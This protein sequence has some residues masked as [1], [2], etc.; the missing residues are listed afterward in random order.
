MLSLYQVIRLGLDINMIQGQYSCVSINKAK[1]CWAKQPHLNISA[2]QP[3]LIIRV[4]Q[5]HDNRV[6]GKLG[7]PVFQEKYRVFIE[8]AILRSCIL[9]TTENESKESID[10]CLS[11]LGV[12]LR[13]LVEVNPVIVSLVAIERIA[14]LGAKMCG[15]T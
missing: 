7:L 13:S 12:S 14:F 9:F 4:E 15:K 6:A 3:Y 5:P 10:S 8:M 11:L 2:M 1:N